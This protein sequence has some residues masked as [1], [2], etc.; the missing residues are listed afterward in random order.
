VDALEPIWVSVHH[1]HVRSAPQLAPFVDDATTWSR[2]ADMYRA[3]LA[4]PGTILLLA[5]VDGEL[6]GYGLA[7]VHAVQDTWAHDTW[8]TGDTLGEI[9][10]LGVLPAHRNQ[11][12]GG[13]LLAGLDRELREAGVTDIVIGVVVGNDAAMRLY[14]R[15]G[16]APTWLHLSRFAARRRGLL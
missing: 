14:E 11:G 13:Q 12:I 6:V 8:V 5:A 9:E 1:Q 15:H 7:C 10:S 3:L 4:Q 2:R 16:Y